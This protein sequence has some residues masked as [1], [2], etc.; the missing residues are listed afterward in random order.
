MVF[1]AKEVIADSLHAD[2]CCR[3]LEVARKRTEL[4]MQETS[5]VS[6]SGVFAL[7]DGVSEKEF[8]PRLHAFLQHFIDL[9][10]ASGY[11]IMRREALAGFGGTLPAFTYRGEL[12]YTDLERE[13]AAYEY[14][15]QHGE[16]VHSLHVAMNSMVKPDADFFLESQIG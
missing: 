15:K 16:R 7:R 1:I 2:P 12:I 4:Q 9:G 8:L 5:L 14:V 11:R 13:H 3:K 10:F 6:F